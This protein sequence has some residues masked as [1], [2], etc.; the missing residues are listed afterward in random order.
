M[1][2]Y[3]TI[4]AGPVENTM[5]ASEERTLAAAL[6][7]GSLVEINTAN[8]FIVHAMQGVRNSFYILSENKLEQEDVETDIP[9]GVTGVAYYPDQQCFFYVRVEGGSNLIRG[10]TLLTS[11]GLGAL[12]IAGQGDAVLFVAEETYNVPSGTPQ[13]VAVRP[14]VGGIPASTV[15][16]DESGTDTI[17]IPDGNA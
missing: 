4:F 13:L 17:A 15:S 16:V 1:A 9:A 11:D 3:Q 6:T 7:P 5:P 14:Y 2:R 8:E 12:E 10:S